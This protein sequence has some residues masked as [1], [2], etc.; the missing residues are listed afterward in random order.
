MSKDVSGLN[1]EQP[2]KDGEGRDLPELFPET[3]AL[4]EEAGFTA[5]GVE[6]IGAAAVILEQACAV[7]EPFDLLLLDRHVLDAADMETLRGIGNN[8]S[9]RPGPLILML[10]AYGGKNIRRRAGETGADAF[11]HK[12]IR[13][14]TL[15]AAV[16]TLTAARTAGGRR[17]EQPHA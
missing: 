5:A 11:L 14:S 17:G 12:P 7:G 9:V 13:A 1:P 16:E 6:D 2:A 3:A 15:R 10:S 4:L 8:P